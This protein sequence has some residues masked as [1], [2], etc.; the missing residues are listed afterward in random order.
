[1]SF[2]F[3][4]CCF[5]PDL[6]GRKASWVV[7]PQNLSWIERPVEALGLGRRRGVGERVGADGRGR[8]GKSR[9]VGEVLGGLQ[10]EGEARRV[11]DDEGH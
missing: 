7:S 10:R 4:G 3:D 11:G 6:A 8:R 9:P 2:R 5:L 1:M